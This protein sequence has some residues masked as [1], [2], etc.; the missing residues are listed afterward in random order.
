MSIRNEAWKTWRLSGPII[1]GELTQMALGIIDNVM[2]GAISYKHLA[3]AAL[4][5]S[6]MNI[7]FVLGIGIT[8]SVSQTV[9]MAHGRKDGL[10]V[11]HYLYN[12]FWLCTVTALLIAVLLNMGTGILFHLKQD[13]EVAALAA[14]YMRIMAWSTIPM[15]MFIAVKQFTDGLERTR[16]AM[17]LSMLALPI[18]IGINWLLVYGNWGFPRWELMG[19]G[20]GTLIT[21]IIILVALL[22]IVAI[23]PIFKRYVAARR[24]QWKLQLSTIRE[25]LH[26]GVPASLQGGMESGAF[27]ISGIIIGTLGAVQQAAHHIALSCAAFTFMVSIGLA[28]GGSIRTSNAWGRNNW[29]DIRRI[30]RSTVLSGLLYGLICAVLFVV[31]RHKLPLA[32]NSDAAVVSLTSVLMLYAALFQMSDAA[33][34]VGVGLLRGMKDVRIPTLYVALA[35]WVLGIPIGCLMAF[36]FEMGAAGMWIGFVTGLTCSAVFLNKRVSGMIGKRKITF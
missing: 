27:A 16:T 19:A 25:L 33:Q 30:A 9:S 21:R 4:V 15:L 18:N 17:V 13:A 35:Y 2:V 29:D 22:L 1:L 34:A 7:P 23:H 24:S 36:T 26:I 3:A 8:M 5:N 10:R 31:L 32:F 12:G 28:Q 11:S 20:A 14:P 6:V